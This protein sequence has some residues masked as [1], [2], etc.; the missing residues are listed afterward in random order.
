MGAFPTHAAAAFEG[1]AEAPL[2]RRS[3]LPARPTRVAGLCAAII[4][5]SLVDLYLTLLYATHTGMSEANPLARLVLSTG[6]PAFVA[7]WKLASVTACVGI[8]I[9]LRRSLTAELAAWLG[10]AVLTAL[11]VHWTAYAE[12]KQRLADA[13]QVLD[14]AAVLAD[15][16]N[17]VRIHTRRAIP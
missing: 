11:T 9:R 1:L 12:E 7:L 10:V 8:L 16:P 4:A 5:L 14:L 17:Y 6:S 3:L 2:R 15:D 13:P